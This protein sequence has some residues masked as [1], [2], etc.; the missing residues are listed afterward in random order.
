MPPAAPAGCGPLHRRGPPVRLD[1]MLA[2]PLLLALTLAP[3]DAP[4][5]PPDAAGSDAGELQGEW[6]MV[7]CVLNGRDRSRRL[8][9]TRWVVVGSSH[10][11]VYAAGPP[12]LP[13]A[14]RV[15]ASR[16]PCEVDDSQQDG[17]IDRGIYRRTGDELHWADSLLRNAPRPSSFDPAPG[18]VVWTLRRVR[19]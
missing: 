12:G 7:S 13:A 14:V 17:R 3:A 18:V 9:A 6:E 5:P 4:T 11:V 15:D 19:K 16:S 10:R 2:A 1:A 8:G